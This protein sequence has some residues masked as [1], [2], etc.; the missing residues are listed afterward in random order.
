MSESWNSAKPPYERILCLYHDVEQDIDNDVDVETC[1]RMVEAWLKMEARYGIAATYNVTGRIYQEQGDLVEKILQA[2]HEIAFHSYSHPSNWSPKYYKEEVLRCRA[3]SP[4]VRGYR[5]PRSQWNRQTLQTMWSNGFLWS[6]EADVQPEPY[7]IY[8][9]LV[10]IPIAGD[11]WALAEGELS[12]EQWVD[13]FDEILRERRFVAF[14]S[15]DYAASLK[16]EERLAAWEAILRKTAESHSLLLTFSEAAD[17]F[18]RASLSKFYSETA[19]EWTA[20]TQTLYRTKR[21]R[22]LLRA[23]VSRRTHP[24]VADLGSGGGAISE[25]V[26]DLAGK[27]LCVDN[28]RGMVA[29]ANS[30][31]GLQGFLGD[32]TDSGLPDDCCDVVLCTRVIEYLFW[33]ERAAEE[34]RRIGKSGGTFLATFPARGQTPPDNE[35]TAPDKIRRYFTAEE[36]MQ[37]A[38]RI[39]PSRLVGI[40]YDSAEPADEAA[41]GAYRKKEQ[42]ASEGMLPTNWVVIGTIQNKGRRI[43]YRNGPGADSFLFRFPKVRNRTP[44]ETIQT[45]L[46]KAVRKIR[47]LAGR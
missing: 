44:A 46:Q 29:A 2:G 35:G 40:Q 18:R 14:G 16:P 5:S 9:G 31:P 20:G 19:R 32:V 21:F 11:D 1:R 42:Q 7:F 12:E 28:A 27:I 8:K 10:R 34:I 22:E 37:W 15:H 25:S 43:S 30:K 4:D 39:G 33:P 38:S 24:V 26:R 6:A 13:R 17:L 45:L 23:E 41:E 36:I 47:R 3:L